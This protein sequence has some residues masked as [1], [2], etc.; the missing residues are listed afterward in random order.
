MRQLL[1][2]G[3]EPGAVGYMSGGAS[4]MDPIFWVLHQLFEKALHIILLSPSWR[5]SFVFDWTEGS[6]NGS[7]WND[8]LPFTGEPLP[9]HQNLQTEA[10]FATQRV[11]HDYRRVIPRR[12]GG[13]GITAS[14][15]RRCTYHST[16]VQCSI[17]LPHAMCLAYIF[18]STLMQ[19]HVEAFGPLDRSS[20]I[21]YG[22]T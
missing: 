6:C 4:P 17:L 12:E 15:P 14:P 21:Y 7:K 10:S 18:V 2:V 16:Y 22:G 13:G 5:D 11:G 19:P 9:S 20:S 1:K 8:K 3:C